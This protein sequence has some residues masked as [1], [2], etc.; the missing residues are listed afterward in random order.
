[1]E[2]W[3]LIARESIRHTI[4]TYNFGG[5]R[6]RLE[7]LAAAFA[8]DGSLQIDD[9]PPLVGREAIVASLGRVLL[10]DPAPSFLHHHVAATH[11]RSVTR[12]AIE[13][14][15]YFQVLSDV[16]LDHWGRYGD[17]FVPV[18]GRWLLAR[19]HVVTSGLSPDSFFH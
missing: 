16:G 14:S 4:S 9:D 3:E 6:G 19:R 10:V 15:S 8:P 1:M 5:D 12:E 2:Q 18:D 13:T 7:E 17:R 11:F